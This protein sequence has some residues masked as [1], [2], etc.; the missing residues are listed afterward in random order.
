MVERYVESARK[1]AESITGTAYCQYGMHMVP[2]DRL[3]YWRPEKG[4]RKRICFS[5]LERRKR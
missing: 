4:T 1:A 2:V 5:C 3:T